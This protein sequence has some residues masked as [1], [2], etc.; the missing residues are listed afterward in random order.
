MKRQDNQTDADSE[1]YAKISVSLPASV[2]ALID[3]RAKSERRT[4]SNMIAQL[5]REEIAK[6]DA[7]SDE[8]G[9]R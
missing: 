4:R 8:A 7:P 2:L 5:I 6:A 9:E 3:S 1:Q